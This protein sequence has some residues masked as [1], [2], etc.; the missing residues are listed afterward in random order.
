M[1]LT[2]GDV[3]EKGKD[4]PGWGSGK[5]EAVGCAQASVTLR[6]ALGVSWKPQPWHGDRGL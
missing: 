1:V 2:P 5:R 3:I 4:E 6:A